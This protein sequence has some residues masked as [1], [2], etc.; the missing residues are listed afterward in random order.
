MIRSAV[1]LHIALLALGSILFAGQS[2]SALFPILGGTMVYD[3]DRD[4]TW[5]ADAN[6]AQTSG[7]DADGKMTWADAN[8]WADSLVFGG[9]SDWRLPSALNGDG[10]GPD[11]TQGGGEMSHLFYDEFQ[12]SSGFRASSASDPNNYLALFDNLQD[13]PVGQDGFYW[14]TET[15]DPSP[16]LA[17][18]FSMHAGGT[19]ANDKTNGFYAWAILDGNASIAAVP[20]PAGIWL[21][22]SGLIGLF[23]FARK[24]KK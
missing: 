9:L 4:I 8:A 21:F 18:C 24:F 16:V 20:L 15:Y 19:C 13:N 11:F 12:G 10:S 3:D 17:W 6:Y 22:G 5:L 2:H 7:F 14:Y 23:G 1:H